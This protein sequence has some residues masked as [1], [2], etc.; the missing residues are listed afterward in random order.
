MNIWQVYG[1]NKTAKDAAQEFVRTYWAEARKIKGFKA[2]GT[3]KVVGGLR[4]Y[5]VFQDG[6]NWAVEV[7]DSPPA[8]QLAV[9]AK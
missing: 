3:F 6:D 9:Y 8:F 4:T 1:Y 5:R 2:D 7:V